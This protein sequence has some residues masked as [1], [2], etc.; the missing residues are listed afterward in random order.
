MTQGELSERSGVSRSYIAQ[1]ERGDVTNI[2]IEP[3]TALAGALGVT[4]GYLIGETDDVP[5]D[6]DADLDAISEGRA[7]YVV[8]DVEEHRMVQELFQL[9]QGMKPEDQRLAL[10]LMRRMAGEVRVIGDE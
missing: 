9:F 1:V 3:L 4:V 6:D 10:A 5:G 2:G 7:V 8:R